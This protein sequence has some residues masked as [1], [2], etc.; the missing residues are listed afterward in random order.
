[1]SAVSRRPQPME[2]YAIMRQLVRVSRADFKKRRA[3]YLILGLICA[4]S[5]AYAAQGAVSSRQT[6]TVSRFCGTIDLRPGKTYLDIS[7]SNKFSHRFCIV[8]KRGAT[9]AR[10]FS[11][12]AGAVGVQ[13]VPGVPGA[14]G[15]PGAAGPQG[16]PG[17]A[18]NGISLVEQTEDCAFGGLLI[19]YMQVFDPTVVCN[20]APGAQGPQGETGATGAQG[21]TGNTG[22]AGA[23]GL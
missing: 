16:E 9:G 3:F 4:L 22:P 20:G 2:V 23:D 13:G 14:V 18:G 17:A 10:G 8:G 15:A 7:A 5:F 11:G 21:P 1:A 19:S 12:A 6:R